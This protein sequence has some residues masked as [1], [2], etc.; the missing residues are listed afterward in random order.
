MSGPSA[1]TIGFDAFNLPPKE[2][3]NYWRKRIPVTRDEWDKMTEA[4]RARAF[5]VA[6]LDKLDALNDVWTHLD[7]ML[8][9]GKSLDD[10]R[11]NIAALLRG[12]GVD[13]DSPLLRRDRLDTI[14]RTNLQSAYQ[15]GHW[16]QLQ[17]TAEDLPYGQYVAVGDART[18]PSHMALDGLIYPLDHDFWR[19]HYPPNGFNCRCT[20]V[21]LTEYDVLKRGNTVATEMPKSI[22]VALPDGRKEMVTP[23]PD[24]GFEG[25]VGRDWL[26]GLSPR[27][28]EDGVEIAPLPGKRICREGRPGKGQFAAPIDPC[29]TPI[30]KIDKRHIL[31]FTDKDLLPNGLSQEEYA[32]AFLEVFGLKSL[33]ASTVVTVPGGVQVVIDKRLFINKRDGSLKADKS[34]RGPYLKLLAQTILN[35]YEVWQVP[36]VISGMTLPSLRLLRLFRRAGDKRIGGFAA[37]NLFRGRTWTGATVF[38]PKLGN[39]AAMLAYLDAQRE[40]VLLHREEFR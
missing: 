21:G 7:D 17:E 36:V 35:P 26:A 32:K 9:S 2:A 1:P 15:A 22:E 38:P 14:I 34:G 5:T 33:D 27:P 30:D 4:A 16:S 20:V 31:P 40:G 3:I 18:R 25:N 28:L 37:F 8:K 10:V 12:H 11:A 39:E 29:W 24:P 13:A 23:G 6:G 19:T